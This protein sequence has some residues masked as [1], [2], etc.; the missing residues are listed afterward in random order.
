MANSVDRTVIRIDPVTGTAGRPISVEAGADGVAAGDGGVWVI[1]R[2]TG[3][4]SRIDPVAR[5]VVGTTSVGNEPAAAA[6]GPDAVWVANGADGTVSK[7]DPSSGHVE[8]FFPVGKQPSGIAVA[9][10]GHVWV[11]NAGSETL[12]ELDPTTGHVIRTVP[13]GAPPGGVA[14][15]GETAYVAA[16]VP[17]SAHRGGT[18]TLAVANPP[19]LYS[20][21]I[22]KSL[23]PGSGYSAWELLSM[24]NDGLL[25]YSRAGGAEAYKV[26]PDLA[27]GLPT[28]SDG[29]LT[30][31]FQLR[32]GIRYSTGGV[33][34][35]ADIRRGI[36]RALL[37]SGGDPPG[38]YLAVIE[39][40]AGCLT[41]QALRS[42]ARHHDQPGVEHGDLPPQ[43]ARSRLPVPARSARLRRRT[44]LDAAP[45]AAAAARDRPV[46]DR[47]LPAEG[48]GRA[49]PE[50]ALPRLVDGGA[51][52]RLSR[53]DRRTVP[54]HGAVRDPRGP[55]RDRRH[56]RVR[57]RSDLA[58][59]A[60]GLPPDA[61]LEPAL[62]RADPLPSGSG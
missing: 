11:A 10:D 54:V 24:T 7:I 9:A 13:I 45:R 15:D 62:P 4:L 51:A 33:V 48:R 30:Y 56:H 25:T 57:P 18:L 31:T 47:R 44:G 2:S 27:T 41:A 21:P 28:R 1:G 32:K 60:R 40:G 22:P 14:L 35:P 58:A 5:T 17:P 26:V 37:E 29:G 19:G 36:E 43:Q 49:R 20:Q 53:Q 39:G 50:P 3:V 8:G 59:K 55:A 52:G 16:R 42:H 46:Q 23:D 6:V 34:Q 12:T 38:S 61:L